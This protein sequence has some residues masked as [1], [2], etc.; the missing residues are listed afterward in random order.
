MTPFSAHTTPLESYHPGRCVA[1][2]LYMGIRVQLLQRDRVYPAV[3]VPGLAD[4]ILDFSTLGIIVLCGATILYLVY[5]EHRRSREHIHTIDASLETDRFSLEYKISNRTLELV[6]AQKAHRQELERIAEFGKL[7]KGLF[8]DLIGPLSAV[9]LSVER[10]ATKSDTST[11][12]E[13]SQTVQTAVE[14]SRRMASFMESIRAV[15]QHPLPVPGEVH[16][17]STRELAIV[18]D[19]L[20]YKARIAGV[21]IAVQN[22]D[23]FTVPIHSVRLQQLFLNTISNAV[24]AHADT[25]S[26]D[27]KQVIIDIT[28]TEA[29]GI[30]ISITDNGPGIPDHH[31]DTILVRPF[32]T[33]KSGTGTGLMTVKSIV[34]DE[35]AGTLSI[36]NVPKI[37]TVCEIV[38]PLSRK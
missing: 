16:A 18:L 29:H 21:T 8:H 25:P 4:S 37:G 30:R 14:A 2:R 28:N 34:E 10:L 33:K 6:D 35:L 12:N 1:T 3:F 36:T 22:H 7:S 19:L 31:V 13:T 11:T 9:S 32:T 17:D 15:M 23:H 24:E 38:I 26:P 5:R 20:A 27:D